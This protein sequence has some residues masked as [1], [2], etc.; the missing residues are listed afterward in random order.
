MTSG[1]DLAI[2][3][4][5]DARAAAEQLGQ[6]LDGPSQSDVGLVGNLEVWL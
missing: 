1:A 5:A 2:G 4:V 3:L 6:A